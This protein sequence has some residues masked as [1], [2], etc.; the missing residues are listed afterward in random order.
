MADKICMPCQDFKKAGIG[1]FGLLLHCGKAL[2]G[3]EGAKEKD[4]SLQWHTFQQFTNL[5]RDM[6]HPNLHSKNHCLRAQP[7]PLLIAKCS[8][9][10]SIAFFPNQN[11]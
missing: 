5:K 2:T 4:K 1:S 9:T 8:T 10:P 3:E 6:Q 11:L 7:T